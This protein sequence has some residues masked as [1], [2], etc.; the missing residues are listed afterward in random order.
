[1]KICGVTRPEDAA[2]AA[3]AGADAIGIVFYSKVKRY[4]PPER[5]REILAA[6]PPFVTPVGLFVNASADEVREVARGLGLRHVQ[7]HGHESADTIAQLRE[8]VVIK[9]LRVA[10]A[11]I[12]ADVEQWRAA[13][14]SHG[15]AN[16]RGF[17]METAAAGVGGTGVEN[18]W[19]TIGSLQREGAFDGMP[20]IIAAGGLRPETVGAVVRAIRPTA[21]DV[22]SGV[23]EG[24]NQKSA[25]K[26]ERF[27]AEVA[28][29]DAGP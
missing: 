12:R 17:V 28:A 4:V 22:S 10:P 26:I 3:R 21:V 8:F 15:L 9:A 23:E 13:I 19:S 27:I 25:A 6:L 20:A 18:D 11:T 7:L 2:I 5:A 14:R 16:L 1:V 29:A 24:T